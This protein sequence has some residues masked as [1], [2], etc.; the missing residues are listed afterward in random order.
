M[1]QAFAYPGNFYPMEET[2]A[3]F[4]TNGYNG[5]V[6]K[7]RVFHENTLEVGQPNGFV[8][9][10]SYHLWAPSVAKSGTSYYLYVPDVSDRS[11]SD[12]PPPNISTSSRI[13]VAKSST[14]FGPFTYQGTID[15]SFGYMS[16]PDVLV[17]GSTRLL[18]WAD[19][20]NSTCGGFQSALLDSDMMSIL[21][22]SRQFIG[23]SGVGVLGDCDGA[24]GDSGPYM[25]GASVYF[26]G[27]KWTIYFAAKPTSTPAECATSVG[28]LGTANEVI[29]R[30]TAD[31]PQGPYTYKGI[32][33][34]GSA[35]SPGVGGEWTNQATVQT[36]SNGRKIIVYHDS[37]G[38]VKERR[39]HAECLFIDTSGTIVGGVY[40]QALNAAN[41]FDACMAGTNASF[42][43]LHMDDPQ[44]STPPIIRAPSDGTALTANRYA[45]G[46]WERYKRVDL[47]NLTYAFQALSNN[48]YLCTPNTTT[49][50]S[51]SCTST[52]STTA[53]WKMEAVGTGGARIKSVAHN[54]YLSVA[55]NGNLYAS[56][57]VAGDGAVV[58]FL[59]PGGK[60]N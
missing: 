11:D 14:P 44:S 22:R 52:S 40:R 7:G 10:N 39:L 49:A 32:V 23:I 37:V 19:G 56:G 57:V 20:D 13:A 17:N 47:G 31:F 45:V 46:P 28:G 6:D 12:E 58:N 54:K 18:L 4:S 55:G 34:C 3:Y 41:G 2:R 1:G 21:D 36:V 26:G 27:G 43:G 15:H 25:E 30:A 60:S 16:D 48:K 33:M 9:S 59:W 29:A 8:P 53:Q 24:G 5:W 35:D 51:A 38:S 50:I 42:W